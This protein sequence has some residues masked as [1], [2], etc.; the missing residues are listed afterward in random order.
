MPHL[1]YAYLSISFISLTDMPTKNGIQ[2][3]KIL[4]DKWKENKK[5]RH[6]MQ[7]SK[8]SVR[9]NLMQAIKFK[10]SRM[11]SWALLN[12]KG[13]T[14][15]NQHLTGIISVQQIICIIPMLLKAA[16][17]SKRLVSQFILQTDVPFSAL[18]AA[19]G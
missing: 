12:W 4:D 19:W 6:S 17:T 16:V 9:F 11:H 2:S 14:Y 7:W 1:F 15:G 10:A 8:D 18:E 5:P 3:S 13:W